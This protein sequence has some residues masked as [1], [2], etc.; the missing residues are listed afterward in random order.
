MDIA[1]NG[2]YWYFLSHGHILFVTLGLL[3][4]ILILATYQ[5]IAI[6]GQ[7]MEFGIFMMHLYN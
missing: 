3:I 7:Y 4:Q 2:I 6:N 1:K 5:P